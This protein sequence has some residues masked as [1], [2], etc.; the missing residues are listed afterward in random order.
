MA[1]QQ[2][3]SKKGSGKNAT[4][5]VQRKAKY[6][7]YKS[8]H[9]NTQHAHP[10]SSKRSTLVHDNRRRQ[11]INDYVKAYKLLPK[12]VVPEPM[13]WDP[14]TIRMINNIKHLASLHAIAIIRMAH[15]SELANAGLA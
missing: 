10:D 11:V 6:Q 2:A 12:D 15:N 1:N 9:G 8:R 5:S 7:A 3:A 4:T 14:S 13:P